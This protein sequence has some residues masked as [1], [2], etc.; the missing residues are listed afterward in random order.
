MRTLTIAGN[1]GRDSEIK[2]T[3]NGNELCEFS[4]A[5]TNKKDEE[6]VWVKCAMWGKRGLAVAPYLLKGTNV[7]VI[8][9]MNARQ[10]EGKIYLDLHVDQLAFNGGGQK[11]SPQPVQQAVQPVNDFEDDKIPF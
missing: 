5:T 8:G 11:Q 9:A 6:T 10:H 2:A 1:L 3:P 4:V 7:T